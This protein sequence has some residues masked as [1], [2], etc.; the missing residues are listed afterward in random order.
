MQR[1]MKTDLVGKGQPQQG[2]DQRQMNYQNLV[3]S[4][5]AW[6][7]FTP[8]QQELLLSFKCRKG[9]TLKFVSSR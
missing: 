4:R 5:V 7:K 9:V 8:K 6:S 3:N 2:Q 1:L